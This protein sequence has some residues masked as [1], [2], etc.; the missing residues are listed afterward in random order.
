MN[1]MKKSVNSKFKAWKKAQ[2]QFGKFSQEDYYAYQEHRKAVER[3]MT[4]KQETR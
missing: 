2:E 3:V 1:D 4:Y